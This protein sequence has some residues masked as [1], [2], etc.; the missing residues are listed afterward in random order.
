[1]FLGKIFGKSPELSGPQVSDF[2]IEWEPADK[3]RCGEVRDAAVLITD[4]APVC[5]RDLKD[6]RKAAGNPATPLI[7]VAPDYGE[8][9]LPAMGNLNMFAVIASDIGAQPMEDLLND[10]SILTGGKPLF[11]ALGT[12]MPAPDQPKT[13]SGLV[14][15]GVPW[16]S[17]TPADL[18]RAA[19]VTLSEGRVTFRTE[20][21]RYLTAHLQSLVAQ[22]RRAADDVERESIARRFVRFGRPQSEYG[23]LKEDPALAPANRIGGGLASS[24]FVTDAERRVADLKSPRTLV[25]GFELQN[26]DDGIAVGEFI[27]KQGGAPVVVMAPAIRGPALALL[28]VNKMC[29]I[30]PVTAVEIPA[31]SINRILQLTGSRFIEARQQ[32]LS[33]NESSFGRGTRL[34]ASCRWLVIAGA[35]SAAGHAA[36]GL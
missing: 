23:P 15:P 14:L 36:A 5:A 9:C 11:S 7:L 3:T 24:F 30:L 27:L 6:M 20:A 29:G 8:E 25:L 13:S 12:G 31:E 21:P 26:L 19:V 33:L 28:T 4:F 16:S 10:L 17:L 35:H 2:A 22:F 18:G 32:L 34:V 1:M